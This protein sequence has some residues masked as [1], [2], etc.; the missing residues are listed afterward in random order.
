MKGIIRGLNQ[1]RITIPRETL[2]AAHMEPGDQAAIYCDQDV[3]G[4]PVI[5]ITKYLG[6]CY[7]CGKILYTNDESIKHRGKWVCTDCIQ[8]LKKKKKKERRQ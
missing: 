4:H 1:G 7:L 6:G 2:R 8:E 3:E 5:I